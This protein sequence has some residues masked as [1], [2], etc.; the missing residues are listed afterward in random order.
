MS[1]LKVL[2]DIIIFTLE[3]T[4]SLEIQ[5]EGHD[6]SNADHSV[7]I[8]NVF[9]SFWYCK[10]IMKYR[11]AGKF[12][13]V[14][15][16]IWVY[17][18]SSISNK[19]FQG[20]KSMLY[21][22]SCNLMSKLLGIQEKTI[23]YKCETVKKGLEAIPN[24]SMG[25]RRLTKDVGRKLM[26]WV[27]H[28]YIHWLFGSHEHI[29][30]EGG[31]VEFQRSI[32][33]TNTPSGTMI[34]DWGVLKSMRYLGINQTLATFPRSLQLFKTLATRIPVLIQMGVHKSLHIC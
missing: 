19:R 29:A 24:I 18:W 2:V 23:I 25:C 9:R 13:H 12:N 4:P 8:G 32:F 21:G 17:N 5:K 15:K 11:E 28:I 34:K 7:A 10:N 33:L 1:P 26:R 14:R 31:D 22:A 3:F 6:G 27:K 20:K 16:H 30:S